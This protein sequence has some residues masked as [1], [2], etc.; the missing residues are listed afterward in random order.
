[1]RDRFLQIPM[2]LR[3][4]CGAAF[5]LGLLQLAALAFPV[6]SPRINGSV[7]NAPALIILIGCFHVAMGWGVYE[8]RKWCIPMIVITPFVQCGVLYI[9]KGLPPSEVITENIVV[10]VAWVAFFTAYISLGR[11]NKYFFGGYA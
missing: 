1:M 2:V 5:V 4:L 3:I 9:D 11:A 10:S 8:K 7:I 6:L